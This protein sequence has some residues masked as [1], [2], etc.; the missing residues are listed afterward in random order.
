[1][2]PGKESGAEGRISMRIVI[3]GD[4]KVGFTLTEQLSKEGHDITV[5]DRNPELLRTLQASCDVMTVNGNGASVHILK[6]AD[7][8]YADLLIAAT[9]S[10]EINL[11]TCF[12]AKKLGCSH[13]ISRIRNPEYVRQLTFLKEELGLDM[14]INPEAAA[15]HEIYR[16]LQFPSFLQRDTFA[17]GRVEIV[18]IKMT[19][20]CSI[21]GQKLSELYKTIKIKVLICAV[22]RGNEVFIPSGDFQIQEGDKIHVTAESPKLASLLRALNIPTQ[23]VKDVVLIGGSRIAYYLAQRLQYSGIN[24]KIIE[25]DYQR[26]QE[27][28]DLL[29][30]ALIINGD[31][32][33]KTLVE[34]EIQNKADVLISL[35]NIDEVNLVMAVFA[36]QLGVPISIAKIDRTEYRSVYETFGVESM[37]NPKEL[38]C[39][40]VLRYVRDMGNRTSG[41]ML[42][43]HRM[44]NNQVEAMEFRAVKG[45]RHLGKPLK[46]VPFRKNIL[47]VSI[48]REG[49]VIFPTGDDYIEAGD[50][51]IIAANSGR[52]ITEL[53]HIYQ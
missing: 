24:V 41:S 8:Q 35:L 50:S 28:T 37:I 2:R 53:N 23:K 10:D 33:Q 11:L 47:V 43:L 12:T 52:P 26:C 34:E 21:I 14:T 45:T 7:I 22:E 18:E 15:A 38:I 19:K 27:L 46:N 17:K 16:L 6:E 25:N 1:M 48:I 42:T 3:V 44:V 9:S 32:S 29:P 39:S 31:G 5:I 20:G 36:K 51:V 4:G 13:T 30:K 40:D 49:R